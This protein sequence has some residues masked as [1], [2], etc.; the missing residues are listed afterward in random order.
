MG[1]IKPFPVC[2][3][4]IEQISSSL[5]EAQ[6][7]GL[8]HSPNLISC[9]KVTMQEHYRLSSHLS[10]WPCEKFRWKTWKGWVVGNLYTLFYFTGLSEMPFLRGRNWL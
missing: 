2:S 9:S 3:G 4:C 5:Q 1:I 10:Y 7:P 6:Y 8:D